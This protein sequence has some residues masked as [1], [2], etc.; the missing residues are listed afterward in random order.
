MRPETQGIVRTCCIIYSN[1]HWWKD[2]SSQWNTH[3][4]SPFTDSSCIGAPTGGRPYAVPCLHPSGRP[5]GGAPTLFLACIH[6][7]AHGGAPLRRPLPASI[8][9]P[10]GGVPTPSLACIHR[11]APKLPLACI[12]RGA[13][14]GTPLRWRV[15]R[16]RRLTSAIMGEKKDKTGAS[17]LQTHCF[18]VP[19]PGM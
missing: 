8:G 16:A 17:C 10:T 4:A 1:L 3:L 12:H 2:S 11:G 15:P 7:G 14:R 19:T 6:R 9:A 5:R 13:R 18:T